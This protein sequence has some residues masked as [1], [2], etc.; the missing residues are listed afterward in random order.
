MSRDFAR[1][2]FQDPLVEDAIEHISTADRVVFFCG[3]GVSL[4]QG[5]PTWS[6][7]VEQLFDKF[8]SSHLARGQEFTELALNEFHQVPTATIVD[9]YMRKRLSTKDESEF[10]TRRAV[11]V[12]EL[13]YSGLAEFKS[14]S[15]VEEIMWLA[16]VLRVAGA[17]VHVMTTNYDDL[18]EWSAATRPV[19][20]DGFLTYGISVKSY[21]MEPP[22]KH[23]PEGEIPVVHL[24]GFLPRAVPAS[25]KSSIVLSENDY[26][27]WEENNKCGSYISSMFAS[28]TV[29]MVGASLR[30]NNIVRF[31]EQTHSNRKYRRFAVIPCQEWNRLDVNDP[32]SAI[33]FDLS[34]LSF[35]RGRELEV[36]VLQPDF[37]G[38]VRT[39]LFE[40]SMAVQAQGRRRS[41][42]HRLRDWINGRKAISDSLPERESASERC[43]LLATTIS[44]RLNAFF[45]GV[46]VEV[47]TRQPDDRSLELWASSRSILFPN[48]PGP[49]KRL[50]MSASPETSAA[51]AA[52]ASQG[53]VTG[54]AHETSRWTHFVAVNNVTS[55]SPA[56]ERIPVGA[57]VLLLKQRRGVDDGDA[58][59]ALTAQLSDLTDQIRA[60]GDGILAL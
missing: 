50:N 44:S 18:L 20:R 28:S 42:S 57:T 11:Q 41:Y 25:A 45:E 60:L 56:L 2:F 3:A 27:H 22:S 49:P 54:Q 53:V 38:Q 39:F 43:L 14:P 40:T 48:E 8:V 26:F 31:L 13:L 32:A 52:F 36:E 51:L 37:F 6:S 10:Q 33:R 19:I 29:V 16:L 7:L 55:S 21:D 34:T 4:E 17:E 59:R 24:H 1:G 58:R 30:D 47:W 15:L 46:K 5:L 35:D 12:Q 23:I 9:A